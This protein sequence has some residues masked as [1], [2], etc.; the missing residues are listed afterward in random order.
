IEPTEQIRNMGVR[1]KLNV[2][3]ALI[4]GKRVVLVDDSVVRGTTS[5]KIREMIKEAGAAE[6]HFRI[7]SPPTA[8]PCFY[9]VDTPE[10]AKLLAASMSE[11]EM[12]AFI[13]V[14]SLKFISLNGLYR[15]AGEAA[16]RDPKAPKY[17]DACFSGEYPVAPSDM[18]EKGFAMKA[19]E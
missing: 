10:R 3:R 4:R 13:G 19:A 18:L 16:G 9:G 2:N 6:V 14:D 5:I 1:L 11:E 8:W 12:R 17:C 7:A 15:A